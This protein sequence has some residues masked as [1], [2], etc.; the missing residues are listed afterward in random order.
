MPLHSAPAGK[1][2]ARTRGDLRHTEELSQRLIRLP[3]WVGISE[4]Q[5][6]QVVALLRESLGKAVAA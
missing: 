4:A 5:Q 1:R 3:L 6:M 2:Y